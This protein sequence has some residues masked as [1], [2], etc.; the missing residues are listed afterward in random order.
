LPLS[1]AVT[2]SAAADHTLCPLAATLRSARQ[3]LKRAPV[4]EVSQRRFIQRV[5]D[6]RNMGGHKKTADPTSVEVRSQLRGV[7]KITKTVP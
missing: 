1:L 6:I 2:A 5:G 4:I 3:A 7:R